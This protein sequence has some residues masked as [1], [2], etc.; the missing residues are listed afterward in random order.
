[1]NKKEL[2]EKL[3]AYEDYYGNRLV[4]LCL[5]C[6]TPLESW[7]RVSMIRKL[8]NYTTRTVGHYHVKCWRKVNEKTKQS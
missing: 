7:D 6:N 2:L 8:K 3:K 1:M 5:F 4:N